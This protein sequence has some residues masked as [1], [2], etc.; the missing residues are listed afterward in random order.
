MIALASALVHFLWQGALIAAIAHLV[1][2]S[3]RHGS[4]GA[5]YAVA[6]A[7]LFAMAAAFG[8]TLWL[9]APAAP[10]APGEI[11]SPAAPPLWPVVAVSLW[12]A[13][14]TLCALRLLVPSLRLRRALE[15]GARPLPGLWR[16]RLSALAARIGFTR[17]VTLRAS[18]AADTPMAAGWLR[19][20]LWLPAGLVTRL[21]AE[22]LEAILLH[23]L[24]HL[25][26]CDWL[27]NLLQAAIE[28]ALFFHPCVHWLSR[29]VR[30]ER[31]LCCDA[32]VL[33]HEVDR[34]TYARALLAIAD[35]RA[36]FPPTALGAQGGELMQRIRTIL[37]PDASPARPPRTAAL[38][39]SLALGLCAAATVGVSC[40]TAPDARPGIPWM[41]PSVQRWMP[42][43]TRAA[44]AHALAPDLLAI[45]ALVESGGNP[46]ARSPSGATGLLQ[47]MPATA[48]RIARARGLAA[49]EQ[50]HLAD[51]GT[52]LD[53]GA[54]YLARQVQEFGAGGI[55]LA[56]AA[57]N[58]G[59]TAVRKH[60]AGRGALSEETKRYRD[61][62]SGMWAERRAA[63]SE[64]FQAW[65]KAGG[66]RLVKRALP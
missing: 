14:L 62:V 21:P 34:F 43:V 13:G 26:R 37:A 39:A 6:C 61:W 65:W 24:A 45:V 38:A 55:A 25:R 12:A 53:F 17:P 3:L 50:K 60:L 4:P 41:P 5:R 20:V 9:A 59:E 58:G 46:Q 52:N 51:P 54:W 10:E 1:L 8:G 15:R 35:A 44:R 22:A 42:E 16:A 29:R 27:V 64:T 19:P 2:R 66:R 7:A 57:Y 28:C 40:L 23:E 56:A 48:A 11:A 18:D 36:E 30:S 47:V 32:L 63:T 49:Y 31:E 33:E